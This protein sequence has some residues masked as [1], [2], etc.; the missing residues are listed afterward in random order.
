MNNPLSQV[1]SGAVKMTAGVFGTRRREAKNLRWP[2]W[3]SETQN[4]V[5]DRQAFDQIVDSRQAG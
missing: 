3:G 1:A 5:G 2:G 4:P